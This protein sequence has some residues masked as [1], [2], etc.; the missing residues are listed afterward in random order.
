MKVFL[1]GLPGSGKTTFGKK[2][3]ASLKCQ[4]I[5]TD[6]EIEKS[7]KLTIPQIFKEQGESFFRDKE[8]DFLKS[9]ISGPENLVVS[10]GGGLP[11]YNGNLKAMKL[12]GIVVFINEPVDIILSRLSK[13]EVKKRPLFEG[14][15][16][17]QK[18]EDLDRDRRKIYE[19]A[20]LKVSSY[21]SIESIIEKIRA[22]K[23]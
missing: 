1:I 4:F 16:V 7:L 2:L 13:N 22:V 9:L 14:Q 17:R 23:F 6:Q 3:A 8:T 5:D 12:A 15:N 18:L 19:Q 21:Q 20:H 10:T 11:C